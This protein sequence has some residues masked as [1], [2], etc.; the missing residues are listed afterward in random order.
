[1]NE[2]IKKD[3]EDILL[4]NMKG[5]SDSFVKV[6]TLRSKKE[7]DLIKKNKN[8]YLYQIPFINTC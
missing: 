8:I 4:N 5:G 6:D 7:C 2:E 3:Q 1:M